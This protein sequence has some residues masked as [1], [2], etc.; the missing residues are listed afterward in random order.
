[1]QRSELDEHYSLSNKLTCKEMTSRFSNYEQLY[2][3]REMEYSKYTDPFTN[4]VKSEICI[5]RDKC[6]LC[7]SKNYR[8]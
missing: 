6:P 2:Q 3:T 4:K 7:D 8:N 5:N 1:M